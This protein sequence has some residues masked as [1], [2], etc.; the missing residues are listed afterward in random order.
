VDAQYCLMFSSGIASIPPTYG[1]LPMPAACQSTP[2]CSCLQAQSAAG[3]A[4]CAETA[5]GALR[6]SLAAP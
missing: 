4:T 3:A 2:T 5:P 6:V 1:C